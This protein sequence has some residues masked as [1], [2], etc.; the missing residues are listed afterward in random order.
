MNKTDGDRAFARETSACQV[1][2]RAIEITTSGEKINATSRRRRVPIDIIPLG[3][4]FIQDRSHKAIERQDQRYYLQTD[5]HIHERAAQDPASKPYF[6][7][8]LAVYL[9]IHSGLHSKR[10]V[11]SPGASAW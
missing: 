7:D 2:T 9:T 5:Q 4:R 1:P 8:L 11:A 10:R 3:R 6:L